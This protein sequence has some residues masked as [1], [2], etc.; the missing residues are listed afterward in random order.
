M[1]TTRIDRYAMTSFARR[2]DSSSAAESA[3]TS[4]KR[5]EVEPEEAPP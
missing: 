2:F 5:R 1:A 4:G 3:R